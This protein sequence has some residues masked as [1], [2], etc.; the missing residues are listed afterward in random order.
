MPTFLPT[1]LSFNRFF[2]KL[3]STESAVKISF[4][5]LLRVQERKTTRWE[6]FTSNRS[7]IPT[8]SSIEKR[9]WISFTSRSA[10]LSTRAGISAESPCS[11]RDVQFIKLKYSILRGII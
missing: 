8:Y 5:Q 11:N 6:L 10:G 4:K 9:G 7:K 3:A 1:S 2:R